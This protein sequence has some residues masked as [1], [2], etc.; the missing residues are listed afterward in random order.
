MKYLK[1]LHYDDYPAIFEI[2]KAEEPFSGD[3]T[4]DK[5]KME[6][7]QSDGWTVWDD[8]LLIGAFILSNFLPF[9]NVMLNV[10]INKEHQKKL[11]NLNML[12]QGFFYIFN[13]LNVRRISSY[14]IPGVTDE[15]AKNLYRLGFDLE[16]FTP[17]GGMR[18]SGEFY[19][20]ANY[21]MLREK[22]NFGLD[23]MA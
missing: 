19:N 5:M 22:R 1:P 13:V 2:V 6:L 4:F 12:K 18:P 9:H 8:D 3:I 15:A 23:E 7:I 14:A 20:V 21:G 16:G 17:C 10:V 11:L